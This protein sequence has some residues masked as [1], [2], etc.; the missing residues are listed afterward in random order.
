MK[1]KNE[2]KIDIIYNSNYGLIINNELLDYSLL[3]ITTVAI[4]IK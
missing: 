3:N 2:I 4:I 1:D